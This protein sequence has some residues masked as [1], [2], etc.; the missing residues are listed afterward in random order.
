MWRWEHEHR[1]LHFV[2]YAPLGAKHI[3]RRL[4]VSLQQVLQIQHHMQ[5]YDAVIL[6]ITKRSDRSF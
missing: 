2:V 3:V 4:N 5:R 1:I 6:D